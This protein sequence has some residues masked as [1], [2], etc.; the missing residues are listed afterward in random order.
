V[1]TLGYFFCAEAVTGEGQPPAT[2]MTVKQPFATLAPRYVPGLYTFAIVGAITD[3][4]QRRPHSV[5]ITMHGPDGDEVAR[6]NPNIEVA[7]TDRNDP[8]TSF[9][10]AILLGNIEFKSA[11]VYRVDAFLDG[12]EP[13]IGTLS[14]PVW[15]QNDPTA[16]RRG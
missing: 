9:S 3:V 10:F 13:P 8:V 11:G 7:P 2:V 4:D 6:T 15:G 1:P 14:L 5:A 16:F 12:Q